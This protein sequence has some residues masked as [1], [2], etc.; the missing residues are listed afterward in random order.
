ME[1]AAGREI[2]TPR[3]GSDDEPAALHAR[4]GKRFGR[5]RAVIEGAQTGSGHHDDGGTEFGCHVANREPV[6][7]ESHQQ[8]ARTLHQRHVVSGVERS[9]VAATTSGCGSIGSARGARRCREPSGSG[10]R[11][12]STVA[13]TTAE[14]G[15]L[16]QIAGFV[17]RDAGLCGLATATT[18]LRRATR[19]RARR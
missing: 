7:A 17:D 10:Y 6:G 12:N 19:R 14:P 18:D 1:V 15:H 13:V 16:R 4:S 2:R 5:E 3:P 9:R 8:P 11:A